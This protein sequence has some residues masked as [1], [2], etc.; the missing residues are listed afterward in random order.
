MN[1]RGFLGTLFAAVGAL[2]ID[3]ASLLWKP[4][5]VEGLALLQP[6]ALVTLDAITRAVARALADR[7]QGTE[8]VA[9][10]NI[11]SDGLTNQFQV[12][13]RMPTAVWESGLDRTFIQ[14]VA[15]TLAASVT[16]VGATR[17]GNLQLPNSVERGAIVRIPSAGV[18]VQGVQFYDLEWAEYL[19]RFDVVVGR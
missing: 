2:T 3:P 11:G 7:W 4:A 8:I 5:D 6:E 19:L 9:G 1:R 10:G 13:A 16:H 17:M 15:E 18:V 12:T 14:P